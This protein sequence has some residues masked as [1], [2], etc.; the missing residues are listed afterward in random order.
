M[1]FPNPFATVPAPMPLEENEPKMAK[2][3]LIAEDDPELRRV[4]VHRCESLGLVV[5]DSQ[6]AMTALSCVDF[7]R[8]DLVC[9][10]V[11]LPHGNGLSVCEMMSTD[12]RLRDIPVIILTGRTDRNTQKRCMEMGAFY[13]PKSVEIWTELKPLLCELLGIPADSKNEDS[14]NAVQRPDLLKEEPTE[15]NRYVSTKKTYRIDRPSQVNSGPAPHLT[16]ANTG[17]KVLII[18]DD[19]DY[20]DGLE[21]FFAAQGMSVSTLQTGL[22]GFRHLLSHP[23]DIVLLD[24]EMPDTNGDYILGRLKDNPVTQDIPVILLTGR[25]ENTLRRKAL[26]MGAVEFLNKPVTRQKILQVMESHVPAL[27]N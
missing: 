6:D 26:N 2:T 16:F 4:L 15:G 9:L 1:N 12:Q 21:M 23:A 19:R 3:I 5:L 18:D 24:Y 13:I 25:R 11:G 7:A 17:P 14:T 27:M 8:P 10:D 22:G 20:C